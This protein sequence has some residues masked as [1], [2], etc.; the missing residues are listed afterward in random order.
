MRQREVVEDEVR[1]GESREDAD[2]VV[3]GP[4]RGLGLEPLRP[5]RRGREGP[6]QL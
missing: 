2:K 3:R 4:V 1:G 5:R 6:G